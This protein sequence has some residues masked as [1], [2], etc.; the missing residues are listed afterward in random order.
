M[1]DEDIPDFCILR[2]VASTLVWQAR[3]VPG[4][5]ALSAHS[6]G[7]AWRLFAIVVMSAEN[8]RIELVWHPGLLEYDFVKKN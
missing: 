8:L 2:R 1:K 7:L 4:N 5:H 6:P 3:S